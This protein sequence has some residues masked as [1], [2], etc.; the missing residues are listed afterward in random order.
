MAATKRDS[1]SPATLPT[2]KPFK[3]AAQESGFSYDSLRDAH[4]RGELA[5]IRFNRAWYIEVKELARFVEAHTIR[6]KVG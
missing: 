2:V 6:R 4:F 5:I 3:K 1:T